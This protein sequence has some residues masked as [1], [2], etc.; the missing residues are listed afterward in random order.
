[1]PVSR[2]KF[3]KSGTLTFLSAGLFFKAGE[4][5]FGQ[6]R[7]PDKP[8]SRFEVPYDAQ[9]NPILYYDRA[10]FEP[11]V[12]GTFIGRDSRGRTVD[13][14]LLRVT[15]YRPSGLRITTGG[16]RRTETFTLTF[17]A[18]RSLPP[19]TSIHLIEHAVLGKFELFLQPSGN[20]GQ[21]LYQAVINH[22][23]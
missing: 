23:L 13:L 6:K 7:I 14:Q 12:G 2:R 1:M 20:D 22:L 10:T 11:Y 8:I 19:F 4:A 17:S 3:I 16:T 9:Q 21:L 18:A 15:E 5:A